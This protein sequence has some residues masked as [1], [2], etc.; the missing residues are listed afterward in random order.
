LYD[1]LKGIFPNVRANGN[2]E[3]ALPNT[4]SLAFPGLKASE[5][6]HNLDYKVAASAGSACHSDCITI[7]P[8]LQAMRVPME[9]AMGT[10][11]LSTGRDTTLEKIDKAVE[12]IASAVKELQK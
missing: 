7:S 6:L 8:V 4:L 5:L 9:Y 11:R 2:I 12:L 1:R 3:Y 10:V